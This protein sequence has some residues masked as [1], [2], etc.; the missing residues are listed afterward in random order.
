MSPARQ[1]VNRLILWVCEVLTRHSQSSRDDPTILPTNSGKFMFSPFPYSIVLSLAFI[2]SKKVIC[3]T[4]HGG[5][6]INE[7]NRHSLTMK[8][9]W[10]PR[11]KGTKKARAGGGCNAYASEWRR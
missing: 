11:L 4:K 7:N 10:G 2:V 8:E 1:L 3:E 6:K 9:G 5:H